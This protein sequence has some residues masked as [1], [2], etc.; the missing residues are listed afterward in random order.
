M[1]T[2]GWSP[3]QMWSCTQTSWGRGRVALCLR[4]HSAGI[5]RLSW[6]G[7][8]TRWLLQQSARRWC[9]CAHD[10]RW[11]TVTHGSM[12]QQTA[13]RCNTLQHAAPRCNTLQHTA[14]HWTLLPCLCTWA[15]GC[16]TYV[17]THTHTHTHTRTHAHTHIYI[18]DMYSYIYSEDVRFSQARQ[19]QYNDESEFVE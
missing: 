15:I 17:F 12:L 16:Q 13:T 14:T 18:K 3:R 4:P 1:V 8:M 5:K 10:T 9:V 11:H 2:P 7:N 6:S 19:D